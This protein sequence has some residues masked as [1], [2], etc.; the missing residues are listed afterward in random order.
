MKR[1][2]ML[3]AIAIALGA[4]Q[5]HARGFGGGFHGGGFGGGGFGGGFHGG[6]GSFDRGG[7]GGG[8]DRGGFGGGAFD[9]SGFG[10][11]SFDRGGSGGGG[12]D[13]SSF[14]GGGDH[15]AFGGGEF[16]HGEFG[17][18]EL[19]RGEFGGGG[20]NHSEFG[21]QHVDGFGSGGLG[22]GMRPSGPVSASRLDSF[23]GLP[24]DMGMH[25][26][27]GFERSF[28][29]SAAGLSAAGERG[30]SGH[31]WT[32][33]NGATIAHGSAGERGAVVGP[34]GAAAGERGVSG[35]VI[36]G[37]DGNT[38]AHGSAG[39]RGGIVGPN[40]AMGGERGVRGTAVR[41]PEGNVV[42][43]GSAVTRHWSSAD[44]RVQGN[45]ARTNFN[46][47][48]TFG[49]GWY[50][51]YPH[52]WWGWSAGGPWAWA[53]WGA[54]DSW[55]V[56]GPAVQPIYYNYGDNITYTNNNVYMDGEPLASAADYYQSAVSLAQVGEQANAPSQQPGSSPPAGQDP[57]WLSL[58]VFQ[59]LPANE[60][61][62]TMMFQL[63][64]NK[65]GIVRGNYFNTADNVQQPIEGSVDKNTQRISWVVNDRKKI[66][67]DT[68]LYN[69]TKSETPVLVH[70]SKDS[71]E[72][73]L[74]VRINEKADAADK[75]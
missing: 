73:W 41:G 4:G 44:M 69:L 46:H 20:F 28:S 40:G 17:G 43:H 11:G 38:I 10:E 1:L 24:T 3:A 57:Q 16:N 60:K 51:H 62:S 70:M 8:G 49:R 50:G 47:W 65:Q 18:G 22:G 48:D 26:A 31:E 74:F 23:L 5:V 21:G 15:G 2:L 61:T 39:E 6:G 30:A 36:K 12:F 68:G 53:S 58:G 72:Q 75:Q 67:F 59:A 25:Q 63:A 32:G 29:G 19:N 52:A 14:G 9:H 66:I 34:N 7:F 71:T 27:G 42:A 35:T 37:P 13:R 55:F 64:V 45:F 56:F 54:L 33:P